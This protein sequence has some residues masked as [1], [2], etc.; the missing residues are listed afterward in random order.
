M[1]PTPS[2]LGRLLVTAGSLTLADVGEKVLLGD[3]LLPL[4]REVC[5]DHGL[6]DDAAVLPGTAESD[7]VLTTD[8]VPTDLLAI[9]FGLMSPANLG[10]YLVAV[11]V[12][13]LV[14]TGADP[15]GTLVTC[16]MPSETLISELLQTMHGAYV[17][18]AAWGAPVVGGDTKWSAERSLSATAVGLVQKGGRWDRRGA[19]PGD[20]L[21]V[22]G[23][24]GA[25]GAALRYFA[26]KERGTLR[27]T[28]SASQEGELAAAIV[29][30]VPR[31]D[32]L[33]PL[34]R[35]GPPSA[36]IDL[37]DGLAQ[38]ASELAGQSSVK[39]VIELS[40]LP[41]P[42][43]AAAV[44]EALGK[45]VIE[46]VLGIGLS[47]ELLIALPSSATP[48]PLSVRIGHV[49]QGSGVVVETA[50]VQSPLT[51]DGFEHFRRR[52]I[53]FV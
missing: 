51:A 48:P 40:R 30:P 5:G 13:D 35:C 26:G 36:A 8:R 23:P 22:T 15:I 32:L 11:N 37:S 33:E 42:K 20:L 47:L 10:R 3:Y 24:I 41:I 29:L 21:Y 18:G 16:A 19:S 38:C 17:A 1:R 53:D 45:Q 44:A 12:S 27:R 46:L 34:R 28:L 9:R 2:L 7:L 25:S 49:E 43:V 6:G 39:A 31:V 14:A 50:S 52:A 4:C